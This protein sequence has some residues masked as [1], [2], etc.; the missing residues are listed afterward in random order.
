MSLTTAHSLWLAPLCLLLGVACAWI[1]YRRTTER[2]GWTTR[3]ALLLATLRA[4]AIAGIAFFLLEPMVRLWTTEVRKPVIVLAHDGS[5]SLGMAGDTAA[6]RSTYRAALQDLGE[7]LGEAHEVR[8]FT[9]G[10]RVEDGLQ[11][12][13][14]DGRTDMDELL[15]EVYDRFS[16]P[17]L[18]AVVIDGDGIYNRGRDPRFGAERLG[19]PVFTIALGDTTV[20]P[21]LV[22]KDVDHNRIAFLGNEVPVVARVEAHHL[23][24]ARTRVTVQQGKVELAGKDLAIGGDPLFV[25]VPLMIKPTA[26]GLQR[27]T[28]ALRPVN[29]ETSEVN[30]RIDIHIDV[31]DDRQK[32]LLLAAAPH[33]DLA[34]LRSALDKLEGYETTLAYATD[35]QGKVDDYDLIVLHQLPGRQTGVQPVLQRAAERKIPLLFVLGLRSDLDAYSAQGAG[36]E[37]SGTHRMTADAQAA[38]N[39]EFSLFTLTPEE[40]RVY[41]RFPPLQVPMGGYESAMGTVP[42]FTQRVGMVRTGYPLVAFAQDGERHLATVCGEGLWRWRLADQ[43]T[44]GNTEAFDKLIHRITQFL[45]L[46]VD[47]SRFRVDH[48]PEFDE[49]EPVILNAELYNASFEPVNE[50]DASIVLTDEAGR[51]Y[52]YDLSRAGTRYRLD[53]GT[54]PAGRYTYAARTELDKERLTAK[55]EFLVRELVAERSTTVAD[56]GLLADLAARTGGRMV[57]PTA[58]DSLPLWLSAREQLV[59]RSYR[60]ARYSDLI[61]LRA[62]FFVLLALLAAEWALRRRSGTY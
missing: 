18:G 14:K 55:G 7:Q 48:A 25:E 16:G 52:P 54:L 59:A 41:E 60:Q 45:A 21:D 2:H 39:K 43:R 23:A 26:P 13:Q 31:V 33:P 49:G 12:D 30:D 1:L 27:F 24:G 22:L 35:F 50:P 20:R 17:D 10:S 38:F 6:L 36:V 42:L 15:H 56:H 40:V 32:V 34:A 19:V 58:M 46:K 5:S 37:V 29:G 61:G 53:A 9:Y 47:K 4:L 8:T 44:E 51:E 11:F 28:V 57:R 62:L 3:T